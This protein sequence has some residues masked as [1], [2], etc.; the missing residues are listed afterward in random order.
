MTTLTLPVG[1]GYTRA[2]E[3]LTRF[4][5]G[6]QMHCGGIIPKRLLHDPRRLKMVAE[7][8]LRSAYVLAYIWLEDLKKPLDVSDVVALLREEGVPSDFLGGMLISYLELVEGVGNFKLERM[9]NDD[10]KPANLRK[11]GVG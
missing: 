6:R 2:K 8:K 4:F 7:L 9:V 10:E 3:T 1:Q 11:V 5:T